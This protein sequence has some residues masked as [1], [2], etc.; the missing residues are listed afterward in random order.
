MRLLN[1]RWVPPTIVGAL[2]LSAGVVFARVHVARGEPQQQ[3]APDDET[4]AAFARGG[5]A[6]CHT[7]PGIPDAAGAVGPN[8]AAIGSAAGSRDP[9]LDAEAYIRQSI[10]EPNAFIAPQ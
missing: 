9:G 5:C 10:L 6:G 8:L 1:M 7:I 2:L 4:I 3:T